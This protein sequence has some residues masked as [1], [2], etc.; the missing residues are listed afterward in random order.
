MIARRRLVATEDEEWVEEGNRND[1]IVVKENDSDDVPATETA[2]DEKD[3]MEEPKFDEDAEEIV[4]KE[5]QDESDDIPA[6][7][8][9]KCILSGAVGAH[10]GVRGA[11]PLSP[12]LG[13]W[14]S[15]RG[16]SPQGPHSPPFYLIHAAR[17]VRLL[18]LPCS[19]ATLGEMFASH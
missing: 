1:E 4:K 6:R 16:T 18:S 14:A 13:A 2:I 5:N 17:N 19:Y 12:K 15:S 8:L 9:R 11:A 10:A 7:V 3:G